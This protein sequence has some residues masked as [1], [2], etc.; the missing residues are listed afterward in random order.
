[1]TAGHLLL[2]QPS[3]EGQDTRALPPPAP[4]PLLSLHPSCPQGLGVSGP[5]GFCS[6][7]CRR[8]IL[9]STPVHA[10][11]GSLPRPRCCT[12]AP[13]MLC[14]GVQPDPPLAV[15]ALGAGTGAVLARPQ[16]HTAEGRWLGAWRLPC[17]WD[18]GRP[19]PCSAL[20]ARRDGAPRG[21]LQPHPAMP[22]GRIKE[23]YSRA[24]RHE[25]HARPHRQPGH[26]HSNSAAGPIS[27]CP[28]GQWQGPPA[29]SG[30]GRQPPAWLPAQ[31]GGRGPS[32]LRKPHQARGTK[33]DVAWK[34]IVQVP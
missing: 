19:S 7:P 28:P 25:P 8:S 18:G 33:R 32:V 14:Q 34:K 2:A 5:H 11:Q 24:W 16:P 15:S 6:A 31:S 13:H 3:P 20:R 1:M 26:S 17:L 29:S 4:T 27:A 9:A 21:R 22:L 12:S 30:G 23:N 10:P